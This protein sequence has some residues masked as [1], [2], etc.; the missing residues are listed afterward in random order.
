[1]TK[2]KRLCRWMGPAHNIG[3]SFCSYIILDNASFL[4]RSSIIPLL[5]EELMSDDIKQQ[6]TDFM[7]SLESK[8]GNQKEPIFNVVSSETWFLESI[9][10]K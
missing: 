6:L 8:I 4:A 3:Q 5:E 7:D 1:M 9:V 2:S 10:F